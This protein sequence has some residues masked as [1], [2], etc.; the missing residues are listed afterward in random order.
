VPETTVKVLEEKLLMTVV[1]QILKHGQNPESVKTYLGGESSRYKHVASQRQGEM[2]VE[3]YAVLDIK[4]P[5]IGYSLFFQQSS[6]MLVF[7]DA[8]VNPL[9]AAAMKSVAQQV[10]KSF[11]SV[12]S[13]DNSKLHFLGLQDL[14]NQRVLKIMIRE[15]KSSLGKEYAVRYGIS[16]K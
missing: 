5:I 10:D 4:S 8:S 14:D 15:A 11:D 1:L 6:G 13:G 9:N 3:G 7:I 12:A 2:M 16:V